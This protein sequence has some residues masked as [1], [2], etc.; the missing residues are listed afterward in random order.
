MAARGL[1][2]L[3][4]TLIAGEATDLSRIARQ[5]AFK[6]FGADEATLLLDG[7]RVGAAGAALA[8]G[9]TI[10]SMDMHDGFRRAKGHAGVAVFPAALAMGES[11]AWSGAEFMAALVCGYEI[12]LRAGIA[13]HQTACD[14]HTSGAW[15]A[16]G[17][18]AVTARALGLSTRQTRHA[19]GI[20]EY[21]GPR[22]PMMRCIDHP[23]MLKDGSGWGGM[24]GVL[25]AQFAAEGF[26]GAPA[27]TLE[28]ESVAPIW[29]DLGEVWLM[30]QLYFKPYAC[31][32]WAQPAVEATLALLAQ[33]RIDPG[34]IDRVQVHT[35]EEA[36][37]LNR[38]R[39]ENT[40]QAQYSLPYPVAAA[41]YAGHLD[42]AQVLPPEIFREPV[43]QLA[44][45]V[46]I[47]LDEDLDSRFPEEALARV[48]IRTQGG[49]TFTSP[50]CAARGDPGDPL[51]DAELEDKFNRLA[52]DRLAEERAGALRQACWEA[53]ALP[54]VAA[55]IALLA[56]PPEKKRERKR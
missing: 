21:H 14:Y 46:G 43:L 1:L 6:V 27:S 48:T 22:S 9:M 37:H 35:F 49:R 55:L 47:G 30:R 51:S 24:T 5:I 41:A 26:S 7:R 40:E 11:R 13:L 19:L 17:A 52:N 31:C 29:V 42:P 36:T 20:A 10:D 32:R 53:A 18:A 12:A 33:H 34:E 25:A 4:A 3:V 50:V 39:P 38:A 23:T 28:E 16:I 15:G 54:D 44:E 45:R 2:D 56:P 8:N